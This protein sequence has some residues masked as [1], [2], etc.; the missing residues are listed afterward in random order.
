MKSLRS[1]LYNVL[2]FALAQ[3][4]WMMLMGIWIYWY[5]TN[6]IILEKVGDQLSPQINYDSAQLLIFIGGIILLV[7]ISF[8][9]S[10]IFRH[11]NVQLKLT[12]LYDN[13]IGNI[14][15][16]LKSPLSSI[17]LY[18][19]TLNARE[20]PRDKQK[21]FL[22]LMLNDA[23]R[24]NKLINSI[25]EISM[26]EQK[27]IAHEYQIFKCEPLIYEL[28][29]ESIEQIKLEREHVSIRGNVDCKI[30]ADRNAL[31]IVFDNL[32]DNAIKY[33][34]NPL[35]VKIRLSRNNK[36]F[37]IKF[38]DNGIGIDQKD[39]K[40]IFNKF[41]R[42]YNQDIPNVKG[43]G[44]GLYWTKEILKQHGGLIT[45]ASDGK[46]KGTTFTIELPIFRAEKNSYILKLLKLTRA[47]KTIRKKRYE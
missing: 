10:L 46:D 15:H 12:N 13:F 32:F 43:T 26:L 47:E 31:K 25:L 45:V 5:I 33:S 23:R 44:L 27:R 40:S 7:G 14:T 2:I 16:E 18:L 11:L 21:E 36:H 37:I 3:L 30:V 4:A 17:Q 35:F 9:M 39:Q 6:Y 8:G 41:Q 29:N 20:V 24:L 22:Q 1:S 38:I 42:I 19:E 28:I 34:I